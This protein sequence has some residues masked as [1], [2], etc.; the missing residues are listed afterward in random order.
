MK[1]F[2]FPP[3]VL[4]TFVSSPHPSHP[5]THSPTHPPTYLQHEL[6]EAILVS[7]HR[8]RHFCLFSLA[9]SADGTRVVGGG[10]DGNVHIVQLERKE[11]GR[12]V[13]E[14]GNEFLL[15]TAD[16]DLSLTHPPTHP[17]TQVGR[18]EAAH[19]DDVNTV[20]FVDAER[21]P[22]LVLSGGDDGLIKLWDLRGKGEKAVGLLPGHA[23]GIT[24]SVQNHPPTHPLTDSPTH[25]PT[26]PSVS[27]K[28]NGLH[29]VSNGKDQ[30]TKLWDLRKVVDATP[31]AT[32]R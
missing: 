16:S 13:G 31:E 26:P 18:I 10:N 1:P 25:P 23:G 14:W 24:R 29:V 5:P 6:H 9:F 15:S 4:V 28:G 8:S 21:R 17:P 30:V 2:W 12:W 32:E 20:C 7:P 22:S 19:F 27:S 11:V 3:T